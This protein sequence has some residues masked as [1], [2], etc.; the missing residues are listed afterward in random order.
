MINLEN[1]R[2]V[3]QFIKNMIPYCEL[4][5][6]AEAP[7][8]SI[9][10]N[11][12]GRIFSVFRINIADDKMDEYILA[13]R[14]SVISQML[15]SVFSHRFEFT[16]DFIRSEKHFT[17]HEVLVPDGHMKNAKEVV[18]KRNLA[19]SNE[20]FF[21]NSLYFSICFQPESIIKD[22][23]KIILTRQII[24]D[25]I[26]KR[27]NI[28]T[29]FNRCGYSATLLCGESLITYLYKSL[30]SDFG[31]NK[32][33]LQV[34]E[35]NIALNEYFSKCTDIYPNIYPLVINGRLNVCCTLHALPRHTFP[36][37]MSAITKVNHSLR[38]FL[39]YSCR[40]RSEADGPIYKQRDR[41]KTNMARIKARLNSQNGIA[42]PD[43]VNL[44]SLIGKKECDEAISHI[45]SA[46]VTAGYL[47]VNIISSFGPENEA[48]LS[49]YKNNINNV[50]NT[51]GI[52]PDYS[53]ASNTQKYFESVLIGLGRR[54]DS[55]SFY[56]LAD[57]VADFFPVSS[58]TLCYKSTHLEEIT[59]SSVPFLT[60]VTKARGLFRFSPS[61]NYGNHGHTI[62]TGRTGSGKSVTLA[63]MANEWLKYANTKVVYIDMGL[64]MLH[65]VAGNKGKIFYPMVD[66]TSFCP[67]KYAKDNK[68]Q[69]LSFIESIAVANNFQLTSKE[70]L[71]VENIVEKNLPYGQ[72]DFE[73]FYAIYKGMMKDGRLVDALAQYV[74][75]Y[76]FLFNSKEDSFKNLPRI[77]G[78]ELENLLS[79]QSK[80]LV[81]PS[82][83]YIFNSLEQTFVPNEPTLLILDEAWR[84]LKDEFFASYIEKWLKQLRKKNT[85]VIIATQ[86]LNDLISSPLCNTIM[87][88]CYTRIF[89]ADDK[90]MEAVNKRC[91]QDIGVPEHVIYS[92]AHL[93]MFSQL[94][95]Q[96]GSFFPVNWMIGSELKNLVTTPEE[97]LAY[98]K[99]QQ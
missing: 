43:E 35:P 66:K 69:I 9:V 63:L 48:L 80:Q 93:P 96:E 49:T 97:K 99:S 61:G 20:V 24:E 71:A 90:A 60:G 50:L 86:E 67:F 21:E 10:Q 47:S 68:M 30:I 7:D 82:L 13:D 22:T 95:S 14:S 56:T 15:S 76:G 83:V 72:E 70:I 73:T 19:F 94:V 25:F 40:D 45:H 77:C 85:F 78:V 38:L 59:H 44:D 84:F 57:N 54:D 88:N 58:N 11:T 6:I 39:K 29:S 1:D 12:N 89:L 28:L 65:S 79:G 18:T 75:V 3:T 32:E 31:E 53:E 27:N 4:L 91:Y 52:L 81:Y 5:E 55:D 37:M 23:K 51:L 33:S 64:S 8:R 87:T 62:I 42:D 34:C 17:A 26:N 74:N 36:D 46:D 98:K 2:K 16:L 41:E 92:I